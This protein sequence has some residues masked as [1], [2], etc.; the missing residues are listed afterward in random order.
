MIHFGGN[1]NAAAVIIMNAITHWYSFAAAVI[2]QPYNP[3]GQFCLGIV[4]LSHC[5]SLKR[6]SIFIKTAVTTRYHTTTRMAVL[7]LSLD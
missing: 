6:N 1:N 2:R 3:T 7:F 5:G 4:G